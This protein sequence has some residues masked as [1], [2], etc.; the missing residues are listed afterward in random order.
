VTYQ[1]VTRSFGQW[2]HYDQQRFCTGNNGPRSSTNG[3][4]WRVL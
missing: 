4:F 3:A 1:G 2:L